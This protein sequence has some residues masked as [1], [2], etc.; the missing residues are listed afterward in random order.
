MMIAGLN[1]PLVEF[2]LILQLGILIF[3]T[4][5]YFEEKRKHKE[6]LEEL[7]GKKKKERG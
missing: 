3:L 5:V 6:L 2:I 7:L 1:L 4:I